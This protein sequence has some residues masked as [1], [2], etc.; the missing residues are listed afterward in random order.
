MTFALLVSLAVC[1]IATIPLSGMLIYH[2]IN[3]KV[4][5]KRLERA[6]AV[7]FEICQIGLSV[8]CTF[9]I[10]VALRSSSYVYWYDAVALCNL[11]LFIGNNVEPLPSLTD[12]ADF[13]LI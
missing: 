12:C 8:T 4:N 6:L 2:D 9:A 1:S 3:D 11:Q 13:Y 10:V 5:G 7:F